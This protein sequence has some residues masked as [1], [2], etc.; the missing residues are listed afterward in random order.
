[1]AASWAPR[2]RL[3]ARVAV[4]CGVVVSHI[5]VRHLHS[6]LFGYVTFRGVAP[7][8]PWVFLAAYCGLLG[9]SAVV[10]VLRWGRSGA[11]TGIGVLLLTVEP[12]TSMLL[13]G[14]G[15]AVGG[16][17]GM[18]LQP[19]I[20]WNGPAV[21][22]YSWTGACSASINLLVVGLGALGIGS[23]LWVH[24]IPDTVLTRLR[25]LSRSKTH[26]ESHQ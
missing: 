1:M 16:S 10:A 15:C 24:G 5:A 13:F 19:Q 7:L 23:G 25:E 3:I 18:P 22:L 17:V 2:E 8:L 12:F 4:L 9:L 6:V 11:P 21:A 14:D 26:H 20:G